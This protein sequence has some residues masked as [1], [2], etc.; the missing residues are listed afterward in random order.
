MPV[1]D[2]A[3]TTRLARPDWHSDGGISCLRVIRPSRRPSAAFARVVRSTVS[4]CVFIGAC[5]GAVFLWGFVWLD[6]PEAT[7]DN[8]LGVALLLGAALGILAWPIA[9][10][11]FRAKP[12]RPTPN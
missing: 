11:V 10:I 7:F 3:S 4:L 12:Q 9:V 8:W 2:K 5:A 6:D 1:H